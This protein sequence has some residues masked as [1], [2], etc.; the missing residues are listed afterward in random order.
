MRQPPSFAR[1]YGEP[2]MRQPYNRNRSG[3]CLI[4]GGSLRENALVPVGAQDFHLGA[5]DRQAGGDP[6]VFF[7][8]PSDR[9]I[10]GALVD[11]TLKLL[12]GAQAEHLFASAGGVSLPEIEEKNIEQRFEFK[13]SPARQHGDQFLRNVVGHAT[14]EGGASWFRH[15]RL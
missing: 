5:Q 14:R 15:R 11:Q 6:F 2:G 12:V 9:S 8:G 10:D 7:G 3:A 4:C 13:R 1:G